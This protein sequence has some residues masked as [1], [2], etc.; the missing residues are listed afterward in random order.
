M[1]ASAVEL[2]HRGRY[3][4]S[5]TGGDS[6]GGFTTGVE[7]MPAAHHRH[8]EWTP[9]FVIDDWFAYL[10]DPVVTM[11]EVNRLRYGLTDPTKHFLNCFL[12][13]FSRER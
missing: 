8:L 9:Q 13:A 11:I 12:I 10:L 4:A 5:H 7:H 2:L 1:T 3:V 6:A